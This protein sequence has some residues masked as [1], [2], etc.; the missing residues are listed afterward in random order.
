[1]CRKQLTIYNKLAAKRRCWGGGGRGEVL[2]RAGENI[3][4]GEIARKIKKY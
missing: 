4:K 1:M 2:K 3:K